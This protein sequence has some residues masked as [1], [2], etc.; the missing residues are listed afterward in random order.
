MS[1]IE[2][3]NP[4]T[5]AQPFS[6]YSQGVEIPAGAR[7]IFVAGQVGVRPDGTV[8]DDM[9]AQTAQAFR[10]IQSVLCAKGMDLED[11]V[12]TRTYMTSRDDLPG[13]RDGRR[14]VLGDDGPVPAAALVFVAG[15][16]QPHWKIEICAVAAKI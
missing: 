16:A 4:D 14:Q 12:E 5:M 2:R 1:V 7:T 13:Y 10:N 8:P 6:R 11:L 15:L 9:A 3:F